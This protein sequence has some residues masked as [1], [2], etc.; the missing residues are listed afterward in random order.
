MTEISLLYQAYAPAIR[1]YLARFVS[2]AEAEDLTQETFIKAVKGA[3]GFR[4]EASE[5][6]WLYRI[7]INTLRDFL[8]SR[9]HRHE[10]ARK[11]I[12]ER[13]LEQGDEALRENDPLATNAILGEMNDCLREFIHRLPENYSSVLVLSDLEGY[14][15][16]EIVEIL[17]VGPEAVKVRLHRARARLKQE[18][19][20]GCTIS[21]GRDNRP[22]CERREPR[23]VSAG[24]DPMKRGS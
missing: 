15:A 10:G 1:R 6:T 17:G 4:G 11:R 5:K 20:Q 7:A 9:A 23:G 16:R 19:S 14:A 3:E 13:E 22:V 2:Q 12:P 24:D 8:K 18:L 21:Y